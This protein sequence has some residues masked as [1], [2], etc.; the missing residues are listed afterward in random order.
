MDIQLNFINNSSDLNNSEIVIFQKN[1]LMEGLEVPTAWRVI[2]NCGRSD[3]H[4]FVYSPGLQISVRDKWGNFTPR[5][6]AKPGQ[7]YEFQATKSGTRLS[8][9]GAAASERE[10]Q[11]TNGLDKGSVDVFFHKNDIPFVRKDDL[12]AG[13][14]AAFDFR[15]TLWIGAVPEVQQG[16]PMVPA[17][18]DEINTEISLLG[19]ASADIVMTG[20]GAGPGAKPR[21]FSLQNV[22][23][24]R[25]GE[26][27][28]KTIGSAD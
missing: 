4:P 26:E 22:V 1:V 3:N 21:Q 9:T 8:A 25:S 6:N 12:A 18:V 10:I 19:L 27:E 15:P 16:E 7:A 23:L 2:E 11:V 24:A 14:M 17:V 20:G 28:R 5:Q 13:Q